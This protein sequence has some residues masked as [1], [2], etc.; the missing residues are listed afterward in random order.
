MMHDFDSATVSHCWGPKLFLNTFQETV[1]QEGD[2]LS[3]AKG[4]R[5]FGHFGSRDC[6]GAH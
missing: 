6:L 4:E 1:L 2:F 3:D 5:M